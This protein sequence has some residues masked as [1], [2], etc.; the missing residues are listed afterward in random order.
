VSYRTSDSPERFRGSH[1]L[2]AGNSQRYPSA[3]DRF[4]HPSI[5]EGQHD[6]RAPRR[7]NREQAIAPRKS[8]LRGPRN[9]EHSRQQHRPQHARPTASAQPPHEHP[10]SS[11]CTTQRAQL[12][13]VTPFLPQAPMDPPT[14]AHA[15]LGRSAEDRVLA[16]PCAGH[17][18]LRLIPGRRRRWPWLGAVPRRVGTLSRRRPS[19]ARCRA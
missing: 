12:P 17:P 3:N 16:H 4:R 10:L 5:V 8:G 14:R 13:E 2:G 9:N 15:S 7:L 19:R 18:S 6:P 1:S 11:S